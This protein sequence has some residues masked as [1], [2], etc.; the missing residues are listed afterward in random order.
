MLNI[1]LYDTGDSRGENNEPL[2][3]EVIGARILAEFDTKVNVKM[4]WYNCDGMPAVFEENF[5]IIGISL[6]MK[7]LEIFDDVYRKIKSMPYNPLL[8][9]G[10][11]VATYGYESL[12]N[13][14]KDVICMIGEGEEVYIQIIN[15]LLKNNLRLNEVNNLAFWNEGK[16]Y[17]SE[18]K[19]ADLRFYVKPMRAFN[20]F[21]IGNKGIARIEGSRGCAWGKCDFC[22]V[23]YKYDSYSWRG[24]AVEK[25]IEQILELAC[26]GIKSIYFTDEDFIGK[27][28]L[29]LKEIIENIEKE[30]KNGTMPEDIN[31][32]ISVKPIDIL[33]AEI[34]RAL[35]KFARVGLRETF[36]G[37]ESGC[38]EQLKRYKKCTTKKLNADVL[39]K[40]KD[41]GTDIDLGFIMFDPE[42]SIGEL[43]ENMGFVEEFQLYNY[44]SN[45][46]K[47][48][49]V[50][51][52]TGF[53]RKLN[54]RDKFVFDLDNLEYSYR[55]ND[56]KVQTIYDLYSDIDWDVYAYQLQN[57]CRGEVETEEVRLEL[58][59]RIAD[60][61]K[62]QFLC[63]KRIY[64]SVIN[65]D[66][67]YLDDILRKFERLQSVK[68]GE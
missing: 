36:I 67:L 14:Y 32:Y 28:V 40:V 9:I 6:N 2:G 24:I 66:K 63:L 68:S 23:D 64:Q 50:Q 44:G 17:T 31:F 20:D 51:S 30:K 45:F 10:N 13:K 33:N 22:S 42:L 11:V 34:F 56:N 1:L 52:Y 62:V 35:Q 29:R 3:I 58:K 54:A 41:L 53:E 59:K 16:I 19:T 39:R 27:D 61:R 26:A 37:I 49:R 25:I 18:R 7:R 5:D 60:L 46:I 43:E 21:I 15:A 55:F 4:F 38:D 8:F 47:R 48:L 65:C 57:V 12:L